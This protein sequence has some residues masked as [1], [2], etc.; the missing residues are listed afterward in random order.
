MTGRIAL[1]IE[2]RLARL[3]AEG[4]IRFCIARYMALCD[5]LG[6]DT[7]MEELGALF[8]R[9]AVWA[10]K[11]R[12]MARPLAGTGARRDCGN[13]GFISGPAA[14]FRDECALSLLRNDH[15]DR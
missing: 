11:G 13:A 12:V 9:D 14:A 4:A 8:T 15:A 10:G 3:E 7:P 6:P 2:Q 5:T 1:S